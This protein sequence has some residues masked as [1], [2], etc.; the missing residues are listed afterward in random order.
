MTAGT[1]LS[2]KNFEI[3]RSLGTGAT[4]EVFLAR[5]L[6]DGG[7]EVALKVLENPDAFDELTLNRFRSEVQVLRA[8]NHPNILRAYDFFDYK[9][10]LA[11]TMEFVDGMDLS[12][13]ISQHKLNNDQVDEIMLQ[14]LDAVHELHSNNIIHRDI[15]LENILLR[16]D[17]CVKLGDL[18]LMKRVDSKALTRPGLIL[19][20]AQYMPPEYIKK[21]VY[22]VRGDLYALGIVLLELLAAKR[23]L[24]NVAEN[25]AMEHIIKSR[26]AISEDLLDGISKGYRA[27]IA[28]ATNLDPKRRYQNALEMR[29]DLIA[30]RSS[31]GLLS[32][33]QVLN[34]EEHSKGPLLDWNPSQ[35]RRPVWHLGVLGVT[36]SCLMVF[37]WGYAPTLKPRVEITHGTYQGLARLSNT[38]F[39]AISFSVSS[40]GVAL[41]GKELGCSNQVLDM[42]NKSVTCGAARYR[43]QFDSSSDSQFS[44]Y[45]TKQGSAQIVEFRAQKEVAKQK[46]IRTI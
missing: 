44:G 31:Y 13:I 29:L 11:F 34:P 41:S 39:T 46:N 10:C 38:Q 32:S 24:H 30:N 16:R 28:K 15:K 22:D 5:A 2:A 8:L 7:R 26:F 1:L 20:T 12:K 45:I 14:V 27:I 42:K 40:K 4:G 19:G 21:G 9:G 6:L 18:G 35:T 43:V 37:A 36:V 3:I 17:G 23:R 25:K 33:G